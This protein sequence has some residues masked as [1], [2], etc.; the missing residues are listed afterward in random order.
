MSL[1]GSS[2]HIPMITEEE[3]FLSR[4]SHK[5]VAVTWFFKSLDS[6]KDVQNLPVHHNVVHAQ[7]HCHVA[8]AAQHPLTSHEPT[9]PIRKAFVCTH[10]PEG[11]REIL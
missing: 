10:S 8:R 2:C 4:L 11:K 3:G 7:F 6:T 9:F 1:P 5:A